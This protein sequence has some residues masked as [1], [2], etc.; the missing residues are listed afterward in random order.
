[1][2]V[3]GERSGDIYGAALARALKGRI[4]ELEIFG[5]GGELMRSAGVETTADIHEVALIGISEVVSGLPKAYRAM[6]RLIGEAVH[7]KPGLA[8]LI[9]SP[10]FN[11]S[12][13]KRLKRKGISVVYYVSPQIWAWKPWRLKKIKAN[14]DKMLCLFDFEETI[15]KKAGVPVE[16]VGHPLVDMIGP[17]R[18][19]EQFFAEAGLD[20][21]VPTVALL[22]GSR[23]TEVSFNLPRILDAAGRLSA[24]RPV[25][26]IIAAAPSLDP[27]FL[28]SMVAGL[29]TGKAVIRV[30]ADQTIDALEYAD[31]AVVASGTATVEAALCERPM[32]V[33][34]RVSPFTA[35]CAKVMIH[36][37]FYSMVNLLAG[38][39][40]VPELIQSDFEA[41]ALAA[42]LESLLDKGETRA[43]MVQNLR[44]V[45]SRLGESGATDRAA[46][47][48]IGHLKALGA[49]I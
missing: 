14:V 4:G 11:L 35:M 45:K 2:I 47:A 26:F 8:V 27:H 31:V 23:K 29:Y 34:Y 42:N 30:V 13:A 48:I 32:V 12:L 28:E 43:K 7:R 9:D 46:N 40:V 49:S 39:S 41:G 37:P 21:S 1:M 16:Y 25:Q 10:S 19:R 38:S 24:S 6:R 5:C 22:P 20:P 18:S 33:V 17:Q 15:Y 36:V 3:A 44:M